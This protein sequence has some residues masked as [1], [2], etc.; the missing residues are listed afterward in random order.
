MKRALIVGEFRF[1][2]GEASSIRVLGIGKILKEIGYNVFF[3]GKTWNRE[4]ISIAGEYEGFNYEN[5]KIPDAISKL[6]SLNIYVRS[7]IKAIDIIKRNYNNEKIDLIICY[8][9]ASRY[10]YPLLKFCHKKNIKFVVDVV[11][12]YDPTHVR[13]GRFGP[14]AFDVS[15]GAKKLIPQCD[16]VIAISS[17]LENY[18][19]NK[20]KKVIRIPV[21]VDVTQSKWNIKNESPFDKDHL[22]II[23]AGTPGKKDLIAAAIV[24]LQDLIIKGY[25][26]KLHIIGPTPTDIKEILDESEDFFNVLGNSLV[27]HGRIEQNCIPQMLSKADFSVL[28]RP[29]K[30]YANA[31]FPTKFVESL[32]IGLPVICNITSD[33]G[34]YLKEGQNGFVMEDYTA[35]AFVNAV[36]RAV[37]ISKEEK[38]KMKIAAKITAKESFDYRNYK[39]SAQQF[40]NTI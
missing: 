12:W 16:G 19:L 6:K 13:G 37:L 15:W 36:K 23:Y 22:N 26:V 2:V 30:L 7:G 4:N 29:N 9:S 11:E 35:D 18:Y 20:K 33:I 39:N 28:I 27:F 17:Y 1:P 8:G 38:M 24:G 25:K 3:V 21:T 40:F 10:I 5:V 32:T 34:M 14:F 31:G